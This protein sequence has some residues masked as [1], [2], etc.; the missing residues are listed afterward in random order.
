MGS[1]KYSKHLKKCG[2]A[3]HH[4]HVLVKDLEGAMRLFSDLMGSKFIGP[5]DRRPERP[6]RYA[7]DTLGLEL[8]SPE[9]PSDKWYP[10]LQEKGEGIL[11]IG[12]KVT[13]IE[14]GIAHF[15]SKGIKILRRGQRDTLKFA[16]FSPDEAH[17]IRFE[18][19]EYD[20][21]QGAGVCNVGKMGELPWFKG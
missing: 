20:N 7:F 11:S 2:C 17:G 19:V 10:I 1:S 4:I 14:E 8:V 5:L 12:L 21:M 6:C 15:E 13:D 16:A 9:G 3:I 18:L